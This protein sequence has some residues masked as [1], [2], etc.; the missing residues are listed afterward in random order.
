MTTKPKLL[1]CIHNIISHNSCKLMNYK[2]LN[3]IFCQEVTI[4]LWG[5]FTNSGRIHHLIETKKKYKNDIELESTNINLKN[6]LVILFI[7][8]F[9]LLN[10]VSCLWIGLP[11]A[12][13]PSSWALRHQTSALHCWRQFQLQW[14]RRY[15]V[16]G[17]RTHQYC[18]A[19]HGGHNNLQWHY[20]GEF[21]ENLSAKSNY[22]LT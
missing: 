20:Q 3:F 13:F 4:K 8:F 22:S 11:P 16:Q 12:N 15:P 2:N 9:F 7:T 5:F 14:L 6:I 19:S 10:T 1:W 18:G 21:Y 17:W